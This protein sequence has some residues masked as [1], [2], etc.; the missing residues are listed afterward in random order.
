MNLSAALSKL[1][2]VHRLFSETIHFIYFFTITLVTKPVT[3]PM[4]L[5]CPNDIFTVLRMTLLPLPVFFPTDGKGEVCVLFVAQPQSAFNFIIS[6]DFL[7]C[8]LL[9]GKN[10]QSHTIASTQHFS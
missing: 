9:G 7:N 6:Q 5:Q 3:F 2:E 1:P 10:K 4:D 8:Y